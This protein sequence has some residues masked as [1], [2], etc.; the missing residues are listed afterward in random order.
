MHANGVLS[1][2]SSFYDQFLLVSSSGDFRQWVGEDRHKVHNIVSANISG[3]SQVYRAY[4][5][6]LVD[7]NGQLM[8]VWKIQF[9]N[10]FV[11]ATFVLIVLL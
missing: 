6:K 5:D 7:C 9:P 4:M 3:F 1:S 10:W 8:K 2:M 11:N